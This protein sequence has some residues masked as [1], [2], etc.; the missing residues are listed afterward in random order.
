M[1]SSFPV[2]LTSVLTGASVGQLGYWRRGNHLLVPEISSR[3]ALYSFR[4]LLALRT[5]VNLRRTHSLQAIRTAFSS[6]REFDLTEHPSQYQLVAH[7]KSIVL[8]QEGQEAIDL[9]KSPG[10]YL[11]ATM[12]DIFAQFETKTG[13]R[14]VDF[15][16]PR[17]H[18]EVRER[19]LGGWPT[20]EN[21]RVPF[22][23][24]AALMA[25][26]EVSASQVQ[27]YYPSVTAE[28]AMDAVSFAD[29]VAGARKAG[30]PRA[31]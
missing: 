6:L 30:V 28:A 27:H 15:R 16:A 4:D 13:R 19:R 17:P 26:G 1:S 7:G 5:V 25:T 31:A 3:P 12:D 14:V 10:S 21:T 9:V 2:D 24:I 20:A 23:S 18:L 22:D 11:L 29:E 8:I